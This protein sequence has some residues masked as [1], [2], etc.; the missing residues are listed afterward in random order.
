MAEIPARILQARKKWEYRGQVRPSF[1]EHVDEGKES[2]WDYPRPPRVEEDR[3]EVVVK[4][5]EALLATTNRAIRVLETASPP[6]FYLPPNDVRINLLEEAPGNSLC[7]WKGQARYWSIVFPECQ[8]LRNVAWSYEDP[9]EGFERIAGYFSFYPGR[10]ECY[11]GG[12][13]V[14]AQPGNIYGGWV[15]SEVVGPFK[16]RPGT[17]SW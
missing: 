4:W 17:E 12:M 2:V 5:N 11:V 9:F 16:G 7:E 13:R 14:K 10:L 15:T 8:P 1:A 6:T 3:R